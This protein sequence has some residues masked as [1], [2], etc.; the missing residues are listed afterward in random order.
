MVFTWLYMHTNVIKDAKSKR[1]HLSLVS[2]CW[3]IEDPGGSGSIKG[4]VIGWKK[5]GLGVRWMLVPGPD[6]LHNS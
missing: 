5:H 3:A 4:Q 6:L 2:A 1:L